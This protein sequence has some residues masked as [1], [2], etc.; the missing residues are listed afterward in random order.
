[1][2]SDIADPK[3]ASRGRMRV[4]WAAGRMPVLSSVK[5]EFCS[6]RP[7][8]GL[9]VGASLHVTSETAN[10]MLTLRDAGAELSLC[11]SNPLSTQDD[12]AAALVA[13]GVEVLAVRGEDSERYHRHIEEVLGRRPDLLVDD[14]GDLISALHR[15]HPGLSPMGATEETTTGV[16]RLRSMAREGALRLPVVAVNDSATK[17]LFDNYYGTGQ[18]TLD[19]IVRSTNLLV[20]GATVVVVGYGHCGQGVAV[21]ADGMGAR[22]IVVEVD[23]V[24]ALQALMDGFG[25]LTAREAASR[26]DIFITVTGN[27]HVLSRDHLAL[28]KDGAILAN[29][30]HFDVEIDVEAL[31]DGSVGRRT[32]RPNLEEFEM[33]DGRRLYLVSEGRLANLGAAEGHPADVM[34]LS[35][36]NQA[37]ALRWL[38]E[39][40]DSLEPDVYVLPAEIDQTVARIKVAALGGSLEQLTPSQREYMAGWRFGT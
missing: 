37:L 14:G 35:F 38:V 9:R 23:P 33:G 4:E 6:T 31:A 8:A 32:V 27:R 11:A 21:R 24:R 36:S 2:D 25:L 30:G 5:G 34:D 15:S 12:V 3:L 29:A 10:L 7:L 26:G 19:G 40:H 18:S 22:V 17:H 16:N 13:E 39:E 20:A 28:M 1:M